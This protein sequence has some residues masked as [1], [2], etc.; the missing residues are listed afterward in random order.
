LKDF[1]K[2]K[3]SAKKPTKKERK[4]IQGK[5]LF[6]KSL[7]QKKRKAL[8]FEFLKNSRCFKSTLQLV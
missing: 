4:K 2:K 5:A 1:F 3:K 7:Q 8:C 6:D